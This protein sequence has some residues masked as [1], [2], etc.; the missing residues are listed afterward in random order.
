[1]ACTVRGR[2]A[3]G[4]QIADAI[5]NADLGRWLA[6]FVGV[7][8]HEFGAAMPIVYGRA[9]L[10]GRLRENSAHDGRGM[11]VSATSSHI[12]SW[13]PEAGIGRQQKEGAEGANRR[14]GQSTFLSL[15]EKALAKRA[16]IESGA[17]NI[18]PR[19]K[20]ANCQAVVSDALA[21]DEFSVVL[22]LRVILPESGMSN[23]VRLILGRVPNANR[24]DRTKPEITTDRI[25]GGRAFR[26]L[27]VSADAGYGPTPLCTQG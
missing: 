7:L 19:P 22:G 23:P 25:R 11:V 24:S 26:L 20:S 6:S 8:G 5:W 14:T 12:P 13:R 10:S 15:D 27:V 16:V 21:G 9:D 18:R 3:H 4:L 1:M 17:R 2:Q